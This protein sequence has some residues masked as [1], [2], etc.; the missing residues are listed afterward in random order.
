MTMDK[1]ADAGWFDANDNPCKGCPNRKAECHSTCGKYLDYEK[2]H[3]AE[4][5]KQATERWI[6]GLGYDPTKRNKGR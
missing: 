1:K 3:Q 4:V 5:K 6:G 2:R